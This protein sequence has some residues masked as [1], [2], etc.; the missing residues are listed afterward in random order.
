MSISIKPISYQVAQG[1]IA[2]M[3]M[4]WD[5]SQSYL[6]DFPSQKGV[7]NSIE[8]LKS[9]YIDNTQTTGSLTLVV[10]GIGVYVTV[11]AGQAGVFPIYSHG[12][13]R[14]TVSCDVPVGRSSLF[15]ADF[16][17][18][19]YTYSSEQVAQSVT[20]T[21]LKLASTD[22]P[23]SGQPVIGV[24]DIDTVTA[25]SKLAGKFTSDL[26][27]SIL[28]SDKEILSILQNV[29]FSGD[30]EIYVSDKAVAELLQPLVDGLTFSS[31]NLNTQDKNAGEI[32]NLLNSSTSANAEQIAS[33]SSG[34]VVSIGAK[35]LCEISF[36]NSTGEA[37]YLFL[38]DATS[39]AGKGTPLDIIPILST[40]T[41]VRNI[42]GNVRTKLANGLLAVFAADIAGSSPVTFT[43]GEFVI[44]SKFSL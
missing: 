39:V 28:V 41:V 2:P 16:Q 26:D 12:L 31:G 30:K 6:A 8:G 34:T 22:S 27:G 36:V 33:A 21:T 18:P 23:V 43:D 13:S 42:G 32:L 3:L 20:D 24:Y 17:Q 40:D 44:F 15:F 7:S 5:K 14:I 4:E 35:N 10:E 19:F 9:V 37:G 29:S 11:L 1:R 38:Y 25:I